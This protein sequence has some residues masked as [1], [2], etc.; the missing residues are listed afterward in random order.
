MKVSM[1]FAAATIALAS[2]GPVKAS[3]PTAQE[4]AACR[5]DA[6]KYCRSHIGKSAE[7]S[8]CLAENKANLSEACRN[9][10]EAHGG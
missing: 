8:R 2:A 9:V 7:M 10:I 4:K 3:G 5:S 6:I 1:L